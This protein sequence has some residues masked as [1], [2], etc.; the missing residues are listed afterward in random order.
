MI[1]RFLSMMIT[2]RGCLPEVALNVD[3]VISWIL[4]SLV[5]HAGSIAFDP[6]FGLPLLVSLVTC[7]L[8]QFGG[9]VPMTRDG[10]LASFRSIGLHLN[11]AES[12]LELLLRC[13]LLRVNVF[14]L[15]HPLR[16]ASFLRSHPGH[17]NCCY[18]S[19]SSDVRAGQHYLDL[20]LPG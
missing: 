13:Q 5:G 18:L 16:R 9:H 1:P 2:D 12:L 15:S 8:S 10:I 6:V 20:F 7:L 11:D 17:R 3:L 19:L 4:W 14:G